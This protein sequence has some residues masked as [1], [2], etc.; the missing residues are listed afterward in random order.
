ML[1]SDWSEDV[2]SSDLFQDRRCTEALRIGAAQKDV[3]DRTIAD[4]G[5]QRH[6]VADRRIVRVAA[7]EAEFEALRKGLVAEDRYIQLGIGFVQV[8]AAD[9]RSEEHTSELQSLMRISYAVFCLKKKTHT[10]QP[11]ISSTQIST[12]K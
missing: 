10:R 9:G 2:C 12:R 7:R 5:F 1:I 8:V 3:V 11:I 4:A 6:L